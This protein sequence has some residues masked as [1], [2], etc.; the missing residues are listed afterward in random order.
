[1]VVCCE[2]NLQ[3]FYFLKKTG[4]KSFFVLYIDFV[5]TF[6]KKPDKKNLIGEK[7]HEIPFFTEFLKNIGVQKQ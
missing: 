7:K 1:M 5:C 3:M 4:I 6:F 2:L